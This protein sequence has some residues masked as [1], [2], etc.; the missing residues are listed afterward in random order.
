MG[1]VAAETL[2]GASIGQYLWKLKEQWLHSEEE[3]WMVPQDI[4][5]SGEGERVGM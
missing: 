3:T 4:Y 5:D 2:M 1:A